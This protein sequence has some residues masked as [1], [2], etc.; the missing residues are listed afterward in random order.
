MSAYRRS[1]LI[2]T[3]TALIV[4]VLLLV[5]CGGPAAAPTQPTGAPAAEQATSPAQ[6]TSAPAAEQATSPAQ[7]TSA[8]AAEQA[9]TSAPQTGASTGEKITLRLWSHEN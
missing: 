8:P 3:L 4:C 2:Q 1:R 7:P 9:A 5:A 6:P